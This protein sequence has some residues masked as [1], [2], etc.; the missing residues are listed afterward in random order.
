MSNSYSSFCDDFYIE[1]YI[2]TELDLPSDRDTLLSFFERIQKQ[3]PSMGSFCRR[4]NGQYCLE[5]NRDSGQYRWV[6]VEVDRIGAG[7]LNPPNFEDA[8]SLER[9]V[10]ELAPYML[11]VN[12]LDVDSLD[13]TLAMDFDC[14]GNHDEVIAEALLES[15]AFSCLQDLPDSKIIGFS[16]TMVTALDEDCRMQARIS[17]ESR[18]SAYEVRSGRY[19]TDEPVSL[20]FTIRRYPRPDEKFDALKSFERQCVLAEQLMVEKI[21][22]NFVRPLANAIAQRR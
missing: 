13:V 8:Y 2:N 16:P 5:E 3:F 6:A 20:Y 12:H 21:L 14:Q 15:T 22:T 11:G 17:I 4:D 19:K 9:L 1:M 18:T 10:I 7:F